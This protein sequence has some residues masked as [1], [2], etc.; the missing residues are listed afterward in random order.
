MNFSKMVYS[1]N[2]Y[3]D[4]LIFLGHTKLLIS[5]IIHVHVCCTN[6]CWQGNINNFFLG[7]TKLLISGIMQVHVCCTNG[8][9]QGN[10][11]AFGRWA[12]VAPGIA[13]HSIC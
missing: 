5:G 13:C 11:K 12:T 10:I 2:N 6:G 7:H 9:W 4:D 3:V 1:R 8:C